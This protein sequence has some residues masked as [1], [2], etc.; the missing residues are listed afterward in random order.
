MAFLRAVGKPEIPTV[1]SAMRP[2]VVCGMRRRVSTLAGTHGSA[3]GNRAAAAEN[4]HDPPFKVILLG[5]AAVSAAM[6]V[7]GGMGL[8]DKMAET[9]V[10]KV[11][12]VL[13]L[14]QPYQTRKTKVLPPR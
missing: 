8:A 14:R 1:D 9:R 5:S 3:N 13:W 11:P 7:S 4:I 12:P 10:K 2:A 6:Q